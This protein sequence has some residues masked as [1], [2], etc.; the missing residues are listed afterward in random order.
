MKIRNG[1]VSN[2]SSSS[3]IVISGKM[4][5][6][7]I[8]PTYH[9]TYIIGEKGITYFSSS[10][11][12]QINDIDSKINCVFIYAANQIE[13]K[14]FQQ[15]IFDISIMPLDHESCKNINMLFDLIK[16]Q[17]NIKNIGTV[18]TSYYGDDDLKYGYIEYCKTHKEN[19][20]II[21]KSKEVLKNF[22]FEEDSYI[23]FEED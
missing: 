17:N 11:D 14:D 15:N 5:F 4:K 19:F 23:I 12:K 1:F 20:D 13:Y 22:I 6:S 8:K 3:F 16:E 21:F 7:N 18:L 9:N 10:F 2:S